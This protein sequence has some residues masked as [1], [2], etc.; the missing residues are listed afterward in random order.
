[1]SDLI[2]QLWPAFQAEVS[3]QLDAL[4]LALLQTAGA[5]EIDLNAVFR[6]FHTIKGGCAMMGFGNMESI[7]HACEDLLDPVRKG[8][9]ALTEPLI[10]ALLAAIDVLK[11]QLATAERTRQDPE[12]QPALLALLRTLLVPSSQAGA[13][14][15]P[16][17]AAEP[18]GHSAAE[19]E[20]GGGAANGA[21]SNGTLR[22]DSATVDGFVNRIG[23]MVMLRNMMAHAM[24]SEEL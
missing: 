20:A 10:D 6:Y 24:Q 17:A 5:G 23:E 7:A 21:G 2:E 3:E 9:Q 22:V 15:A 16:V 12:G 19:S 11:L 13:S 4:E 18:S 14:P 8:S 1:M